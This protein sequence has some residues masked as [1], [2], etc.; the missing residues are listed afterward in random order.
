MKYDKRIEFLSLSDERASCSLLSVTQKLLFKNRMIFALYKVILCVLL[1]S[2]FILDLMSLISYYFCEIIFLFWTLIVTAENLT[3]G[4]LLFV[5]CFKIVQNYAFQFFHYFGPIPS[6]IGSEHFFL[7]SVLCAK[8]NCEKW[9]T[10]FV[11]I[12]CIVTV[13]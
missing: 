3:V 11:V 9:S 2:I 13:L 8:R 10:F 1:V 4:R 5:L 7:H 6:T 12:F